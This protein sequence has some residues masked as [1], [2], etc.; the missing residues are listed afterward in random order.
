[1]DRTALIGGKP[2]L[3]LVRQVIKTFRAVV[4]ITEYVRKH[5]PWHLYCLDRKA[6]KLVMV[7]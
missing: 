6:D 7:C 4:T 3:E 2:Y 5:H 1:M